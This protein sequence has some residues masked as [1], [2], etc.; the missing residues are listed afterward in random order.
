VRPSRVFLL[1]GQSNM[2]GRGFPLSLAETPDPRLTV[3]RD[4]VWEAA[5]DPLGPRDNE[6]NG[7]GP[8]MSFGRHLLECDQRHD[9]G[10][11]MCA[12][13]ATRITKWQPGRVLF[14]R[15]VEQAKAASG[16]GGLA[17]ILFLQGE[18]EAESLDDAQEWGTAFRRTFEGFRAELGTVPFVLGQ[19]GTLPPGRSPAQ[20]IVRDQQAALAEELPGVALVETVDLPM[21]PDGVH[22]T[23]DAYRTLG[24]RFADAWLNLA[25]KERRRLNRLLTRG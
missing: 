9:V 6:K 10:I 4:G 15:S 3:W 20:Q 11:V 19:I 22:F 12:K 14:K 17:G 21:A 7:I 18:Y 1:A 25:A 8:G 2:V 23:P 5:S 24:V 16:R 13:G